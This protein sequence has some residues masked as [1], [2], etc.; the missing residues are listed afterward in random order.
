MWFSEKSNDKS[1]KLKIELATVSY[2]PI[3]AECNAFLNFPLS[4]L[5]VF[6]R[7]FK[8]MKIQ[9]QSI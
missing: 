6:L 1:K 2:S 4:L 9:R 3:Q 7:I 8:Q 5:V